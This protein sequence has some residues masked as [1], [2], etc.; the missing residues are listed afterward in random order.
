MALTDKLTAIADAIRAK[1]GS[2]EKLTLD[3][4]P[5]EIASIETGG[6]GSFPELI[7]E[8]TF[9]VDSTIASGGNESTLCT[10]STGLIVDFIKLP[11]CES[12]LAT[13]ELVAMD[14]SVDTSTAI[15]WFGHGLQYIDNHQGSAQ[16]GNNQR[17]VINVTYP[18]SGQRRGLFVGAAQSDLSAVTIKNRPAA[19][20]TAAGTYKLKIYRLG[21]AY[22]KVE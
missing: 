2:A 19:T 6:G 16:I 15:N 8:T 22:G 13:I 3:Q 11:Y 18:D 7:Y 5:T 10:I 14:S 17:W 12:F 20:T 1:T 21:F 9:E 4:M